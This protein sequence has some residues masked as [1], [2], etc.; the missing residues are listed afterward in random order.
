MLWQKILLS[1][2]YY[3]FSTEMDNSDLKLVKSQFSPV[4]KH[5]WV[6]EAL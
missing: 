4:L 5:L 2:K 1:L 6:R 3:N